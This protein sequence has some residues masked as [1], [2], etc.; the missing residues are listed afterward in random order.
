MSLQ[1]RAS[2]ERKL[3]RL[4]FLLSAAAIPE[5]EMRRHGDSNNWPQGDHVVIRVPPWLDSEKMGLSC[6]LSSTENPGSV[7]PHFWPMISLTSHSTTHKACPIDDLDSSCSAAATGLQKSAATTR[8][9][10]QVRPPSDSWLNPAC[11]LEFPILQS[12]GHFH[13]ISIDGTRDCWTRKLIMSWRNYKEIMVAKIMRI[14]TSQLF[15]IS[16]PRIAEV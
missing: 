11:W 5:K 1:Q 6:H 3:L 10:M 16:R 2:R 14:A 4:V 7:E 12:F 15:V 13:W 8:R 9:I